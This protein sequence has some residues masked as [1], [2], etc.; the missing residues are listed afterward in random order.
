MLFLTQ[1]RMLVGPVICA[2][3]LAHCITLH[4]CA[5]LIIL[6]AIGNVLIFPVAGLLIFFFGTD[7]FR[8]RFR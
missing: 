8:N 7:C 2:I 3:F 4:P 5:F 6:W 1:W